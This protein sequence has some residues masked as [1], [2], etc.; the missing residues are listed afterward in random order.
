MGYHLFVSFTT[1]SLL[2]NNY[3]NN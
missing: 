2:K 3:T 1:T